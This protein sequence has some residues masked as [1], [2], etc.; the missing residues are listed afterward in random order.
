[1]R[2]ALDGLLFTPGLD[3]SLGIVL[4]K[5]FGGLGH[6][7]ADKRVITRS[8]SAAYPISPPSNK[9]QKARMLIAGDLG[10]GDLLLRNP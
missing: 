10:G 2:G 8:A 1:L 3:V 4:V 5:H 6:C 9:Q 7:L